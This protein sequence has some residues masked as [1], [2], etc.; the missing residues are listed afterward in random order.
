MLLVEDLILPLPSKVLGNILL[1]LKLSKKKCNLH[2]RA[3]SLLKQEGGNA[4]ADHHTTPAGC[5]M[6]NSLTS[7]KPSRVHLPS[8]EGECEVSVVICKLGLR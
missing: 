8:P 6:W 7:I 2:E 5:C 1:M 3:V 4:I